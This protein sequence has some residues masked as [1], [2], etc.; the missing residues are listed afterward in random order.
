MSAYI[1]TSVLG[2]YYC[3]EPESGEA[4]AALRRIESPVVGVLSE[5]EFSSW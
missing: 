1:D 5:V 3:P 4:E 2:A